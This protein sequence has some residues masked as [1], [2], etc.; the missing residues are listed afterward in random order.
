MIQNL[1]IWTREITPATGG[2]LTY[3]LDENTG[4]TV[5]DSSGNA[6]HG[7]VL[8][9]SWTPGHSGNAVLGSVRNNAALPLTTAATVSMWVRRDTAGNGHPRVLSFTNDGLELADTNP[10]NVLGVYLPS[11]GVWLNTSASFGTGFHHVAVTAAAGT[12]T[13][14]YDGAQVYTGA[15]VLN[16]GGTSVMTIGER[17]NGDGSSNT[18]WT[19]AFDQ[20]R[21]YDRALT[22]GEIPSPPSNGSGRAARHPRRPFAVERGCAG[23][24]FPSLLLIALLGMLAVWLRF[25]RMLVTMSRL[26]NLARGPEPGA[27]TA[28][29]RLS[30][31]V[32]CRN[33]EAAIRTAISSLLDQD[34]PNLEVVAVDDCSE[35]QTG[36]LLDALA[37]ERP[38]LRVAHLDTLPAGWLGKTNALQH[39]AAA[40]TG[41]WLLF[42]D[43]DIIF[44]PGALRR[45]V[46]WALRDQLGHA[47]ALPH[48]IAPGYLENGFVSFFGMLLLVHLEVNSLDRAGSRGF[49]GVGAFN[50]VRRDAYQA[51]GTPAC[52]SRSPTTSS[53]GCC[54][55]AAASARGPP[56]RA[57]SCACA[58]SAGSSPRWPACSRIRSPAASSAGAAS[59]GPPRA[60]ARHDAAG[61]VPAAPH[62]RAGPLCRRRWAWRSASSPPPPSWSPSCSTARPPA[63]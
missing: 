46:A 4:T 11:V 51:I 54:S 15:A 3:T 44:A 53:S 48:F 13:V 37:R 28:W 8:S 22:A 12:V 49:I 41:E 18:A 29:P 21:V 24:V 58:G 27:G 10:G 59:P 20:V 63:A 60:A 17:Y 26:P 33:E 61:A 52:G 25:G 19:G 31:V 36:A 6:R 34:Y 57:V 2:T 62:P 56:T 50:L 39:G 23:R 9:G 35:D 40:A 1:S 14:Y 47:V 38:A 30:V 45:S 43:A 5:N 7:V 16:L 55:A 32:A 42:T